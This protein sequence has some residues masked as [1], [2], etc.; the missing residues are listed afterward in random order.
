MKIT[1]AN[2]DDLYLESGDLVLTVNRRTRKK[3]AIII[4]NYVAPDVY[5]V[6][7]KN[8]ITKRF[9]FTAPD[10]RWQLYDYYILNKKGI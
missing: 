10:S 9:V 4:L 1:N 5:E 7:F 6:F 2:I 3:S 8:K